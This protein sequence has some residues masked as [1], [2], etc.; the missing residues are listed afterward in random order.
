MKFRIKVTNNV[1]FGNEVHFIEKDFPSRE[2]AEW[3]CDINDIDHEFERVSYEIV[4]E[5]S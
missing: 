1:G 4:G 5:Q 2:D 3:W